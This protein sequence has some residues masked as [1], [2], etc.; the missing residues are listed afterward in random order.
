MGF[1]L[2]WAGPVIYVALALV[3]LYG[4]FCV[5]LLV[6]KIAQKRFSSASAAEQFLD[7][8]RASLEKRD[9]EAVAE[10]CDSP[11]YWSKATPQLILVALANKE[12]GPH[13]LRQLLAEKFERDVLADLEYRFSWVGTIV[14]TAP[15]LG[16]LGTVSGMVLAFD[17]IAE[18]ARQGTLDPSQ[19]SK[20]IS[21]ALIT[22][23]CGLLV[24]IPLTM[25]G[26][27]VQVRMGKLTDSV[28]EHV[29]EFLND[30]ESAMKS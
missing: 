1:L 27:M 26:S 16:L 23:M 22:T 3:A 12:R 8:V 21:L 15:M 11:R 13:K 20:Q 25:L 4:V 18:A 24:A 7:D 9:F 30:L 29:S 17:K 5:I 14:K 6:R 10:L 28:Q 19:L 2:S